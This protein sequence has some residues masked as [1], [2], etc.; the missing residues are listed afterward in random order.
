MAD[1]DT[2]P[3]KKPAGDSPEMPGSQALKGFYKHLFK[4]ARFGKKALATTEHEGVRSMLSEH[5]A[6]VEKACGV[7]RKGHGKLY[8]EHPM[9][10]DDALAKM[11]DAEDEAFGKWVSASQAEQDRDDEEPAVKA[12]QPPADAPEDKPEEPAPAPA[13]QGGPAEEPLEI[14]EAAEKSLLALAEK[15]EL[16]CK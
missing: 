12:E 13:A 11:L 10:E 14:D 7:L 4:A 16:L 15:L 5:T 1:D 9:D 2:K 6:G 3:E 8:K